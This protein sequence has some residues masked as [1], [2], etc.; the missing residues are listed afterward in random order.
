MLYRIL[1]VAANERE[2]WRLTRYAE[3]LAQAREAESRVLNTAPAS[4]RAEAVAYARWSAESPDAPVEQWTEQARQIAREWPFHLLI[5]GWRRDRGQ[6][7]AIARLSED[8]GVDTLII[9]DWSAGPVDRIFISIGG[10]PHSLETIRVAHDLMRAWDAPAEALRI[11]RGYE[12]LGGDPGLLNEY[13]SQIRALTNIQ[14][15]FMGVELPVMVRASDDVA[16]EIV[17]DTRQGDL[18]VLGGPRE[19]LIE[20]RIDESI[21][22]DVAMSADA[23]VVMVISRRKRE[24]ALREVFWENT[25]R[26]NLRPANKQEAIQTLVDTLVEEKQLPPDLRDAVLDSAFARERSMESVV[27]HETVIPHAALPGFRDVIG[28][29]GLCPEGVRFGAPENGLARLVF[30]LLSPKENYAEYLVILS[31]IARLVHD[32]DARDRKS[33]V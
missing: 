29:L 10:G 17:R 33:V 30:F 32:A 21:P 19:W 7:R 15:K 25:I 6:M 22:A 16:A 26:M 27:S 8:L 12:D 11:A 9:K 28:C 20:E 18:I 23:P 4:E 2:E 1:T 14:L 13:L 5:T 24:V 31:K 3:A